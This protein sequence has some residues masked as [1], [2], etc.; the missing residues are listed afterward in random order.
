MGFGGGLPLL[1]QPVSLHSSAPAKVTVPSAAEPGRCREG[2]GCRP[3]GEARTS[4]KDLAASGVYESRANQVL[5]NDWPVP[6]SLRRLEL[7][8]AMR[9]LL[10]DDEG[11]VRECV[12]SLLTYLGH[13]VEGA[14]SGAQAIAVLATRDFDLVLTDLLLPDMT[15]HDLARKI[16][17]RQPDVRVIFMAG[18]IPDDLPR[19]IARVL[20][21]PFSI[22]E[23]RQ[24]LTV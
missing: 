14:G 1:F 19:E 7:F 12:A 18:H 23:L 9:I 20:L 24:S 13:D 15:G 21:K 6:A 5:A 8:A 2:F 16:H 11:L 4:L 10:T 22:Q 3:G 17:Q